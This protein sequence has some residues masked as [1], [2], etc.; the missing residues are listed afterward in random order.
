[1]LELVEGPTLADR[2]AKGPIPID[3]AL[4]IAKQNAEALEAAHE[5]GVI[6]RDL[7]PANIKVR[8]DGTVK[9]LDF[10]LAKAFQPDAGSDPSD[11]PTMTAAATR[12]GVILGTAAYMSPE[13]ARGMP[14]DRRTDIWSFGCVLFEM[15]TGRRAFGG[16]TSPDALAAVLT[17]TPDWTLLPS[18]VPPELRR[19]LRRALTRDVA[20]RLAHV[21]DAGSKVFT[22]GGCPTPEGGV[23]A[24]KHGIFTRAILLDI[25]ALKGKEALGLEQGSGV[26]EPVTGADI[27]AF[28]KFAKVKI[29]PGDVVLLYTGRWKREVEEGPWPVF[30][31]GGMGAAGYH[32]S[33]I[34]LLFDREV[35]Y[36]GSDFVND[37]FPTG[38][39]D[40]WAL[41]VHQIVMPFLGINILDNLDLELVAEF[42]R[43]IGRW[44]F[45][46]TAGPLRIDL[47]HGS[48]LNPIAT[49]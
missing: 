17:A 8:Q 12:A 4:P 6:H 45:L 9:V 25:P 24:M 10:G 14:L 13:Q 20:D 43:E 35:A 44:E 28:E 30:G 48:P 34:P 11:S 40:P 27:I 16:A 18:G 21:S 36:I 26:A 29:G 7:K 2:I 23:N 19:L 49:F 37:V 1:M 15:L 38:F 33:V 22:A 42:A 32:A 5:Q 31:P 3:E 46:I 41:P 39:G 47:G